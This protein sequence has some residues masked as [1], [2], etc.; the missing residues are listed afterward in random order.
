MGI[1]NEPHDLDIYLWAET[2]QEVVT[3]IRNAG[4]WSQWILLPGTGYT[5]AGD[6][7]Y[8]SGDAL[9]AVTNPDGTT[10]NLFFDVHRYYDE[11]AGPYT[12][13]LTDYL[14]Q[15]TLFT[16][17]LRGIRDNGDNQPPRMALITETGGVNTPNCLQY[18][19]SALN[20]VNQNPDAYLGWIGW[21]AG[22]L[23]PVTDQLSESPDGNNQDT[24]LVSMC[25]RGEFV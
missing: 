21:A 8:S 22:N 24:P 1:M 10:T 4:A 9:S 13:C 17:W 5:S 19:C 3:T 7:Q 25:I 23:D 12:D 2:V 14:D 6:F 15:F 11:G 20:Y 16:K 18:V